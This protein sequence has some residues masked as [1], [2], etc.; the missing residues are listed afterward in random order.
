ML[1]TRSGCQHYVTQAPTAEAEHHGARRRRPHEEELLLCHH[2]S[3][4]HGLSPCHHKLEDEGIMTQ[5]ISGQKACHSVQ[6]KKTSTCRNALVTCSLYRQTPRVL[7]WHPTVWQ[8][9]QVWVLYLALTVGPDFNLPP[10]SAGATLAVM[11]YLGN[12]LG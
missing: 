4:Q 6:F 8:I 12:R 11:K 9:P 5:S 10:S 1:K 2:S 3:G 7:L